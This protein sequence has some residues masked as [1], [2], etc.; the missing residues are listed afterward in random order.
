MPA[1]LRITLDSGEYPC[2]SWEKVQDEERLEEIWPDGFWGGMGEPRKRSPNRYYV[3]SQFD[4]TSPPYVRFLP[5]LSAVTGTFSAID[6]SLP[7]Y[8]FRA[9][10]PDLTEVLYLL[11]GTS[12]FKINR[13]TKAQL[14]TVDTNANTVYGRPALFEG[15]WRIPQGET[16]NAY[17]LVVNDADIDTETTLGVVARHFANVQDKG[18]AKLA[19]AF[20]TNRMNLTADPASFVA[21][22]FEVGDS[23]F[24]VTDLLESGGE[25]ICIKPDGP[26]R[27]DLEGNSL[28]I[29]RFVGAQ[30]NP[31]ATLGANSHG[32][33][34]YT[35]W[36]HS[37]GIWRI[38]G[39]L[40]TP[41]GFES[42]PAFY[43]YAAADVD[44]TL[45]W[46]SVVAY[47][48]WLYA[49][50][51]TQIY[52]AYIE[53]DGML[54]WHGS[55][56]DASQNLRVQMDDGPTL[57]IIGLAAFPILYMNLQADGSMR[58][59]LGSQRETG[60]TSTFRL[61]R[62]DFRRLD[63]SKQ[64]RRTWIITEGMSG[65]SSFKLQVLRDGAAAEDVG[66]T[67]TTDGFFERTWTPG[68]LDTCREVEL[69]VVGVANS[70]VDSRFRALGIEALAFGIYRATIVL[71]PE[72]IRGYSKGIRGSLSALRKLQSK[73]LINIK[74]P[75]INSTFSGRVLSIKEK[76]T[77]AEGGDGIGYSIEVLIE[78]TD[79]PA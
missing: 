79:I 6:T 77:A 42:D 48:R 49:S 15:S 19:R 10:R 67:I 1:P 43:A 55:I 53:D 46:T 36:I 73:S 22:D 69:R 51:G 65:T 32:H 11:N 18:T 30:P 54:R 25:L 52:T 21:G 17:T 41:V 29:Q 24:G 70:N 35:Y 31:P 61:G 44:L 78:R 56:F 50:R 62:T 16:N 68:T 2:L 7:V 26:R 13:T 75:E 64:L 33:G 60:L 58:A 4:T 12:R 57:Y 37:S 3:C 63:R 40:I 9:R 38:I 20:S 5:D 45:Q 34:T 28:P 74:E 59:P 76:A 14:G 66:A 47:G 27:F 8:M 72:T 39:E 71:N 23:S